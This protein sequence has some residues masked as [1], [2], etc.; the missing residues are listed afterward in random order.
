MSIVYP[1]SIAIERERLGPFIAK[2]GPIDVDDSS[3]AENVDQVIYSYRS[4][5]SLSLSL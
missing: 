1:T 4:G 2:Y 5:Q 3:N